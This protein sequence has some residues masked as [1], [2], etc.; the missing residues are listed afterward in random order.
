MRIITNEPLIKR[1]S[2]IARYTRIAALLVLAGGLIL[3][4]P[5]QNSAQYFYLAVLALPIGFILSQISFYFSNRF[6]FP[7]LPH[8]VI[9]TNL[10]GLDDRYSLYNYKSPVSHLLVGP[11]GVWIILPYRAGGTIVYEK[12]RWK[13]KG[14][15]MFLKIFGQENLGRP[16]M[17]VKLNTEEVQKMLRKNLPEGVEVPPV[18]TVLMFIG[19]KVQ[20]D[21]EN[22][23]VATI[24]PK[25][26]K[27]T[28][29]RAAKESI[30][31]PEQINLIRSSLPAE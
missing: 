2:L 9:E 3:S 1:N 27:E 19:R 10:K 24:L 6:S 22:A 11:S 14:G 30:V 7:P 8:H 20:V 18:K 29:R 31:S 25:K 15:S 13:Q 23:P 28:V 12:N 5:S 21:A 17:D 26:L 4:F 16:D